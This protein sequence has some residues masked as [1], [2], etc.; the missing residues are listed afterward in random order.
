MVFI[1]CF[2]GQTPVL[3]VFG[4]KSAV[5]LVYWFLLEFIGLWPPCIVTYDCD[6]TNHTS[7]VLICTLGQ[8][9]YHLS[10]SGLYDVFSTELMTS[11]AYVTMIDHMRWRNLQTFGS[12]SF[13][14][15][16]SWMLNYLRT[17]WWALSIFRNH[18][19]DAGKNHV[20]Y[21][22]S[23]KNIKIIF[24]VWCKNTIKSYWTASYGRGLLALK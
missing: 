16:L 3:L 22:Q 4:P 11:Q 5:L 23:N 20:L 17:P 8:W 6:V 9:G 19:L 21:F 13:R 24:L 14:R 10:F 15:A 1:V 18:E 7:F 2:F 12:I